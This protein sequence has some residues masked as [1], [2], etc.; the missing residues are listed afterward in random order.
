MQKYYY[1]MTKTLS[2]QLIISKEQYTLCSISL[3]IEIFLIYQILKYSKCR[4]L[5]T[6]VS[7]LIISNIGEICFVTYSDALKI[8]KE[9]V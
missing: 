2:L 8:N 9:L 4:I 5:L 1:L 3:I 7:F 6:I